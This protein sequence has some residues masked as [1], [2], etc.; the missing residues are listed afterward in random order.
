V[1]DD[2]DEATSAQDAAGEPLV[3]LVTPAF[4][5]APD[6]AENLRLILA[7]LERLAAPFE[8]LVVCDGS[9]D[10]TA[11]RAREVG[12]P[13]IRVLRYAVNEG[14]GFA[15]LHGVEAARG[16]FVGW[17]DA[18]LDVHPATIVEAAEVL[19]SQPV[20]GVLG[21]KR[22]PD[23]KVLYP[24]QRRVYSFGFQMLVRILFRVH[25]TD[26]QVGAKLF[27]RELL[28]VVAPLLVVKRYAFDLEVL[29]VGA[30]FGFDRMAEVPIA[31]HYRF[32]G[33]Q[34]NRRAVRNMLVDTLAIAYRIHIRH[35]YVRRF[36]ALQRSRME[37]G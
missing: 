14:K 2:G 21:S 33:T 3:S 25:A 23:S 7:E 4:N 16:R 19:R 30:E 35:W 24:V 31:L 37:E 9:T 11:D 8:V 26:T 6:I 15:I 13:R 5:C 28:D 20:D 36:A 1:S 27:R 12:D 17:L 32:S 22:H 18:D 10:G 29:A 34:I